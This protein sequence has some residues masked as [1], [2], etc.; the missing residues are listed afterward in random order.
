MDKENYKSQYQVIEKIMNSTKIN[1]FDK[2]RA[3]EQ[4]L[5]GWWTENEI[6]WIWE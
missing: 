5:K 3:I 4:F 1:E 6:A 2:I